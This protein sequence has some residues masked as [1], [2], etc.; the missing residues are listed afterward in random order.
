ML[1][2]MHVEQ[3]DDEAKT[4]MDFILTATHRM[5]KMVQDL[6]EYSRVTSVEMD[7]ENAPLD[8]IL[9][10]VLLSLSQAIVDADA[11]I[12]RTPLPTLSVNATLT[13]QLIQNLIS[14]ALKFR[15][16]A[17]PI[18]KIGAREKKDGNWSIIITDNG[19]GM[20]QHHLDRIFDVFQRLHK[21]EEYEGNGIGLAICKRIV[22]RHGGEIFVTSEPGQGTTFTFS[23]GPGPA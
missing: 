14:N 1:G 9:D 6:L 20:E 22:D 10:G 4:M 18:I 8:K 7:R 19:I 23:Y 17:K 2:Q 21:R 13:H 5:Q 11:T 12:E 3:L 16:E 15:G